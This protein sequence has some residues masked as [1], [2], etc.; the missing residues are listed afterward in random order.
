ML[1]NIEKQ[2]RAVE[3]QGSKHK[4]IITMLN[5]NF[6][7]YFNVFNVFV[8]TVDNLTFFWLNWSGDVQTNFCF[9]I[10][11]CLLFVG[12]LVCLL[13]YW[14]WC[15]YYYYYV[16]FPRFVCMYMQFFILLCVDIFVFIL[17]FLE[18]IILYIHDTFL[19]LIF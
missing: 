1:I 8:N 4:Y 12:L 19:L 18:A 13:A 15:Y 16:L 9:L 14:T 7:R 17:Y 6:G 10:I 11:F 3:Q 5:K 2:C